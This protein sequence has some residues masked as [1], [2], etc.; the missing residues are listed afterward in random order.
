ML[1]YIP[2]VEALERFKVECKREESNLFSGKCQLCI[3]ALLFM[4]PIA[5][6]TDPLA[7]SI[8]ALDELSPNV[9]PPLMLSGDQYLLNLLK[10]CPSIKIVYPSSIQFN[11]FIDL[12]LLESCI[13]LE[14]VRIP[15]SRLT[16]IENLRNRLR[17][18][19]W[20]RG[21]DE[22][23]SNHENDSNVFNTFPFDNGHMLTNNLKVDEIFWDQFGTWPLLNY[24]CISQSNISNINASTMPPSIKTLD[25][26]MNRIYRFSNQANYSL[27]S[28]ITKLCLEYNSLKELPKLNANTLSTLVHLSL[29]GNLIE[30]VIGLRNFTSL[31]YLDLSENSICEVRPLLNE[32]MHLSKTL[33]TLYIERNPVNAFPSFSS[34]CKSVLHRL[35]RFNGKI[36]EQLNNSRLFDNLDTAPLIVNMEVSNSISNITS[37][38]YEIL[39]DERILDTMESSRNGNDNDSRMLDRQRK[40]KFSKERFVVI[41]DDSVDAEDLADNST[42]KY[43]TP[44]ST[45]SNRK[46]IEVSV[47]LARDSQSKRNNLFGGISGSYG[48]G[49][50]NQLTTSENLISEPIASSIKS[51]HLNEELIVA[52]KNKL[53][54]KRIDF[55]DDWLISEKESNDKPIIINMNK[56]GDASND[57]SDLIVTSPKAGETKPKIS[58]KLNETS[59]WDDEDKEDENTVFLVEIYTSEMEFE[60]SLIEDSSIGNYFFVRVRPHD[61][62]L[63]EKDCTTG[64]VLTTLDLKILEQYHLLPRDISHSDSFAIRLL[65]DTTITSKR[66]RIYRFIEEDQ[67]STFVQLYLVDYSKQYRSKFESELSGNSNPYSTTPIFLRSNNTYYSWSYMCLRCG[68]RTNRIITDCIQ[69]GSDLIIKDEKAISSL[70]VTKLS[71]PNDSSTSVSELNGQYFN[72]KELNNS[73]D[74]T[75]DHD[76]SSDMIDETLDNEPSIIDESYFKSNIDHYL[77]LNI[78]ICINKQSE[79]DKISKLNLESIESVCSCFSYEFNAKRFVPVL[80]VFSERYLFVFDRKST[81]SEKD[82]K[83]EL[84]FY[85]SLAGPKSS[86][87]IISHLPGALKN[88]GYWLECCPLSDEKNG[89]KKRNKKN[90]KNKQKLK[91]NES[92]LELF[93]FD[94]KV[95]GKAFLQLFIQSHRACLRS[96]NLINQQ[97]D[98]HQNLVLIKADITELT[99]IENS[100]NIDETDKIQRIQVVIDESCRKLF[101]MEMFQIALDFGENVNLFLIVSF[102]LIPN[103]NITNKSKNAKDLFNVDQNL[104]LLITNE[105]L[106]LCQMLNDFSMITSSNATPQANSSIANRLMQSNKSFNDRIEFRMLIK[107]MIN[108]LLPNI[109]IN[110]EQLLLVLRFRDEDQ[111]ISSDRTSPSTGE[112]GE[113]QQQQQQQ[114]KPSRNGLVVY[115][116]QIQFTN[117]NTLKRV[118]RLIQTLWEDEFGVSLTLSRYVPPVS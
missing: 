104:V 99:N 23:D 102:N 89:N 57:N 90:K 82:G 21:Y 44:K 9:K 40:N 30:S 67:C 35:V 111:K 106:V 114:I 28:T 34:K 31:D 11:G 98:N 54:Q 24:L 79:I 71:T 5:K 116:Y 103:L 78:D 51:Q 100:D 91:C 48:S 20:I 45:I 105:H 64:K 8:F 87:F 115:D 72:D 83:I 3:D 49:S 101:D 62:L 97:D 60:K 65:F 46:Q 14:L 53:L 70:N 36:V 75:K 38:H 88:Q 4:T 66:E 59:E 112:N 41:N 16:G 77:K 95:I 6:P 109:Y 25:L 12:S 29:R 86:Q 118:T 43:L 39:G 22:T 110:K 10:K 2:S 93:L 19:I 47:D 113:Q 96:L 68:H 108:N 80:I 69:C 117:G 56:D 74:E 107:D 55:G 50:F 94:D 32:L 37:Q 27:V 33:K 58:N 7:T 85:R 63:F 42:N 17:S 76:N 81:K 92:I 1:T 26:R 18:L 15:F 13:A 52:E 84:R 73:N 61:G